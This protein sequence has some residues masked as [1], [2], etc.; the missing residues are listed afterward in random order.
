MTLWLARAGFAVTVIDDLSVGHEEAIRRVRRACPEAEVEF[1][2]CTVQDTD[3]VAVLLKGRGIDAVIH[4]AGLACV[5]ESMDRPLDYW[6]VNLGGTLSLLEA[7]RRSGSSR[8]VF[9]S[10]CATYGT[11]GSADI[12]ITE[13][14]VQLPIN[15]YGASKLACERAISDFHAGQARRGIPFSF[16]SLRYFNV[17]G[18]D[19]DGVIGEDHRPETHLVPSCLRAA[20]EFRG[21]VVIM[22]VAHA[23]PDGSCVRDYLDVNDLCEAHHAALAALEGPRVL[24]SGTALHFNVG[25]GAGHSVRE[26]IACCE[27]VCGRSIPIEIGPSREGDPPML[28]ADPSLI[29]RTVGWK[30][31]SVSLEESIARAWRWLRA[32]PRGYG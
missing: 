7:M 25:T 29:H 17:I 32:N 9:S 28:V 23:T 10:T 18:C 26:V 16:A 30:A 13:K 12:P 14:C 31:G 6:M 1:V 24:A 21:P 5:G 4:A 22:G 20:L 27:R 2:E 3:A 8:L 11:P 15:P 19:P